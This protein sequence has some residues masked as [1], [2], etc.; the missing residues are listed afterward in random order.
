MD[1]GLQLRS[2]IDRSPNYC[3]GERRG[4][5]LVA[6]GCSGPWCILLNVNPPRFLFG[7]EVAAC[8]RFKSWTA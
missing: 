3:L 2:R 7:L 4:K 8:C 5:Y 1:D 6:E